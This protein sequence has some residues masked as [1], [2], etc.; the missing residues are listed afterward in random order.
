MKKIELRKR[1]FSTLMIK[2]LCRKIYGKAIADSTWVAW[3]KWAGITGRVR[4]IEGENA[5]TLM[6]IASIRARNPRRELRRSEIEHEIPV[7]SVVLVEA[8]RLLDDRYVV[9][10]CAEGF[11]DTMGQ[12]LSR[13]SLYRKIPNFKMDAMIPVD[14][15]LN[16]A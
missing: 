5:L 6:A 9:G 14:F 1:K 11:L 16:V 10:R 15:L 3:R 12:P 13:S 8:V 2:S 4:Q 7:V